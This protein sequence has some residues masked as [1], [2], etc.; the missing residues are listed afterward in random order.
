MTIPEVIHVKDV[1]HSRLG[2]SGA[3]RWMNCPGSPALIDKIVEAMSESERE[4]FKRGGVAAAEGTAAHEIAAMALLAEKDAWEYFGVKVMVR[5]REFEVNQEMVDGVQLHLDLVR[6]LM[7]RY[8]EQG[9]RMYVEHPMRSMLDDE[10]FGTGDV[11]IYVPGIIIIVIDFK[12]GRNIVVE[13]DS[14]QNKYYGY[15]ASEEFDPAGIEDVQLW[16]TQPRIPHPRGLKRKHDAKLAD[17]E[18]WFVGEAIPAMAETRNPNAVLEIGEWCNFCPAKDTQSCPA[19]RETVD[20]IDIST[21]P[22]Q[23]SD[24]ELGK[25][26]RKMAAIAKAMSA[27]EE[28]AF[29]R[30]MRGRKIPG[31]KLVHKQSNRVFKDG[32]E[33]AARE[34]F[35]DEA[36]N[37]PTFKSP[38][39]IEK[40]AGGKAFVSKWAF[41][42]DTGLTMAPESDKRDEVKLTGDE[43]FGEPDF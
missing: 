35:G 23:L 18:T 30:A 12:Y 25:V 34:E 40:L 37:P 38:P 33:D 28:E 41:K 4:F 15:L 39:N 14:Y 22:E 24:A 29:R 19:I 2:A 1:P 26:L 8:S 7:E 42:P 9:A 21:A 6:E 11:I 3:S 13:P 31:K 10:A 5:G 43:H 27:Y 16:I 20:K 17:L 32:A 36:F